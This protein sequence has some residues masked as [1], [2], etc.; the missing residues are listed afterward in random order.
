MTKMSMRVF[1]DIRQPETR[2]IL[3][4]LEATEVDFKYKDTGSTD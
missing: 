1:G 2:T 4:L 3:A